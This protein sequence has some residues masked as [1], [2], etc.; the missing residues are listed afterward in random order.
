M[1]P[2]GDGRQASEGEAKA[3]GL[4]ALSICESLALSLIERNLLPRAAVSQAI[5][6]AVS[7]H[8]DSARNS[9]E[10]ETHRRA[11]EVAAYVK[12][13]IEASAENPQAPSSPVSQLRAS[14]A[15][16]QSK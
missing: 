8:R 11:A 14:L 3:A 9:P 6:S 13:S 5:E 2:E 1:K 7:A 15:R 12:A 16:P 10:A 4:A